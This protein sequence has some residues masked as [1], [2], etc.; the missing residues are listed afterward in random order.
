MKQMLQKRFFLSI[1]GLWWFGCFKHKHRIS[2]DTTVIICPNNNGRCTE[3]A[4][5]YLADFLQKTHNRNAIFIVEQKH[6]Y[7]IIP[8]KNIKKVVYVSEKTMTALIQLYSLFCFYWNMVVASIYHPDVRAGERMTCAGKSTEE[9]IFFHGI[10]N[11][12]GE[13]SQFGT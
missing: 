9:E 11:L 4:V 7:Q 8:G 2:S 3:F 1:Y 13:E 10:Y 5:K 12:E 6:N